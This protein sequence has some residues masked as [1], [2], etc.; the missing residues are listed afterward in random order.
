MTTKVTYTPWGWTF[1]IVELAEG[2][3]RVL[4]ALTRRV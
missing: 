1:D 3:W 4:D 2:I